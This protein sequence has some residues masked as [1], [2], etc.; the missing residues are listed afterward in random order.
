MQSENQ[1]KEIK[2]ASLL[3]PSR[4]AAVDTDDTGAFINVF[5]RKEI[6][7]PLFWQKNFIKEHT[8]PQ[9]WLL[10]WHVKH[11]SRDNS[12]VFVLCSFEVR[13]FFS[14][15]TADTHRIHKCMAAI[16]PS[17]LSW[18][19]RFVMNYF[20]SR[21]F[22]ICHLCKCEVCPS[23][24]RVH[25]MVNCNSRNILPGLFLMVKDSTA[26]LSLLFTFNSQ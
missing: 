3:N 11:T 15:S 13:L 4:W 21:W 26:V 14:G 19:L 23:G 5:R 25:F 24:Q 7:L 20:G 22:V 17:R 10:S 8:E 2:N 6:H 12:W 16:L 1:V 18:Y 9:T